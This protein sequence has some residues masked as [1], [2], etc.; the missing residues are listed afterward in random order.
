MLVAASDLDTLRLSLGEGAQAGIKVLIAVFLLGV[1]LDARVADLR[2]VLRRPTVLAAGLA[3]QFVLLPAVTLVLCRALDVGGSV[4]LGMLLVACCP[5]GNLSNLLTH[6]ARGD[7]ALSVAMTTAA[8]LLAVLATPLA[9]GFWA[10]RHP[11]AAGLLE[12]IRLD[13]L[14]MGVEVALLVGLPFAAG[15]AVAARR[16]ALAA[17]LRRPIE[18]A[19]LVLLLLVIVT[20][21]LARGEVIVDHLAEVAWPAILQNAV[22]LLLGYGVGRALLLPPAGVR[23]MTFEMGVRNTALALVL[24]LAYFDQL[25]GVAL[26][27][28]FWALWDVL[29]GLLLSTVWRR[30]PPEPAR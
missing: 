9:F 12:D 29:T 23:A 13:P 22:V 11:A 15:L 28:A 4:A 3:A 6:R 21:L 27:V 7:V 16:P 5:A 1:A 25:G 20:G 18:V 30:R 26:V 24:A 14:R 2:A 19:V 8:N 17:R 10:A